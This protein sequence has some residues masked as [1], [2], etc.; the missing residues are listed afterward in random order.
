M[1][2]RFLDVTD[3]MEKRLAKS[4]ADQETWQRYQREELGRGLTLP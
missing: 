4:R 3:E 1:Y 2:P